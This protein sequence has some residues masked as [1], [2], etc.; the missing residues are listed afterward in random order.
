MG[1][2]KKKIDVETNLPRNKVRMKELLLLMNVHYF[3]NMCYV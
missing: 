2:T 1:C 3:L